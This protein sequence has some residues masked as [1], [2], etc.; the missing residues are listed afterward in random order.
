M[1]LPFLDEGALY[2]A[3]NFDL[4]ADAR[5]PLANT[6]VSR[7]TLA[8]IQCPSESSLDLSGHYGRFSYAG[9]NSAWYPASPH[10]YHSSTVNRGLFSSV[11]GLRDKNG[12]AWA[13]PAKVRDIRDGTS[14]TLMIGEIIR[15]PIYST[16]NVNWIS[17]PGYPPTTRRTVA[18]GIR[19]WSRACPSG[20]ADNTRFASSHEGGA[21]F[22]F[23]D[24]SVRFLTENMSAR[25]CGYPYPAGVIDWLATIAGNE[26]VD[27]EDY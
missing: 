16:N 23:C 13:G 22:A 19:V 9:V 1:I 15:T 18:F 11:F 5:A 10:Y 3:I 8:Q 21:Y 6:T 20:M 2:N 27:D 4:P 26:L 25:P 24:G 12:V 17:E 7:S 14:N